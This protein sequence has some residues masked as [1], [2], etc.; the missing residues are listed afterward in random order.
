[1]STNT[2]HTIRRQRSSHVSAL[3]LVSDVVVT[4]TDSSTTD[5]LMMMTINSMLD[6]LLLMIHFS[7]TSSSDSRFPT[8][9][10]CVLLRVCSSCPFS[11]LVCVQG[12]LTLVVIGEKHF[13]ILTMIP[14]SLLEYQVCL[15][16]LVVLV[17][18]KLSVPCHFEVSF[19]VVV[20]HLFFLVLFHRHMTN[21]STN[22][23]ERR[24]DKYGGQSY[25]IRM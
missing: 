5:S 15:T 4:A 25:M 23:Y 6:S 1:M 14:M 19:P 10:V 8:N 22:Q 2:S 11:W 21:A 16:D 18:R 17:G 7:Y 20:V 9:W 13:L 24:I 12:G 3:G